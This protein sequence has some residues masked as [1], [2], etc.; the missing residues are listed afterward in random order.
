MN[1]LISS[2]Q[3]L[4]RKLKKKTPKAN[5]VLANCDLF[6]SS[7]NPVS[8]N[9]A[10]FEPLRMSYLNLQ[11]RWGALLSRC[12][13]R[14][15]E[16]ERLRADWASFNADYGALRAWVREQSLILKGMDVQASRVSYESL[17]SIEGDLDEM[18]SRQDAKLCD[19]DALNDVY[20]ELARE[21]RLDSSDDLKNKFIQANNDWE[22]LSHELEATL[23]RIRHSR[24]LYDNFR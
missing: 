19:L 21:Y 3:D 22:D 1:S 14:F 9:C 18:K 13:E 12:D 11:R 20:C 2:F 23:K 6:F 15:K 8:A 24:Q 7:A 16:L 4:E 5:E 17:G 10:S